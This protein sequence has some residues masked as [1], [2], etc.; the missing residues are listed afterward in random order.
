MTDSG[1]C[2]AV[3]LAGGKSS[4][5]GRAKADLPFGTGTMLDRI[6]AEMQ[7]TFEDAVVAVAEP[8][9]YQWESDRVRVIVDE[10]SYQ[11]PVRALERA[12]REIRCG[13]AFV[14]SCDVPLVSGALARRLCESMDESDDALI[15]MVA[16]KL[17]MLHGVYR[18][19]C[20]EIL[21]TMHRNSEN[22]LHR[23]VDFAKVRIL[24]DKEIRALGPDSD[25][26]SF[27]NV[28]TPE[29]YRRAL[30]LLSDKNKM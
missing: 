25:L 13:R 19:R 1:A 17:Q 22:R 3:I 23:I 12:L 29:D 26:R 8:R 27:F 9:R 10:E 21:A 30:D 2:A 28:N 7:R 16:G 6:I 18:K 24:S 5:M 4:R 11:G 14:C 15:P 20:A